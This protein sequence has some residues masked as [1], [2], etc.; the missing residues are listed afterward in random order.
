VSALD[1]ARWQFG[2]TT[3]YHFIFVPLTIG[4]AALV[5]CMQTAWYF[6]KDEKYLRMTKFWGKLFLINFAIGVV[7][8]IVQE[9]Q[10]GMNWSD[11]SRVVGDIFGAP[12]AME[13]LLAFFVES[14]F[15]GLWI[16]GWDHLKPKLHLMCIWMV[17]IGTNFSAAFILAANSWMQHP[18]GYRYDP[19]QHRAELTDI[20][21]VLTNKVALVTIPHTIAAAFLTAALFLVGVSAWHLRR[22]NEVAVFASSAKLGLIVGFAAAALTAAV[23]HVQGEVMTQVQPMKM[24][25]AEAL[26]DTTKGADF[27]LFAIG[28]VSEGRNKVNLAIPNGLS[29]LADNNPN[30]T[31]EGIN[32]VN[33]AE[34]QKYGPG[35][36][37]P[38]IP[39]TYWTFRWMVGIGL[40]TAA[41]CA[42]GLFLLYRKQLVTSRRFLWL[43]IPVMLLPFLGNSFGWIFTEMGR[44]PWVVYGLLR[45]RDAVS[46]SVGASSVLITLVGF[47]LLYGVLAFV[48]F[49]LLAKYAKAG[50]PEL[51][52]HE[53]DPDLPR[54]PGLVY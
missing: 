29:I 37:K 7:T 6:K 3:V 26:W 10:F 32:D 21:A 42:F 38:V 22:N 41:F 54:T 17:A 31:V 27:S 53:I 30:S 34:V 28:D 43:A 11:Y 16:F 33:A 4:L 19:T 51:Q 39:V 48:E 50:P 46:P 15:L 47:T 20:W 2:I 24:A 25:A 52:P 45:T 49:R 36:Y 14:T 1:L 8:G 23:G 13:G 9:F 5:A 12:L 40:V 35:D 18:V 44:Q